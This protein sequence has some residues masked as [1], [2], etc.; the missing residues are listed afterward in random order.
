MSRATLGGLVGRSTEWVKAVES[1]RLLAPRLPMLIQLA[2]VLGV[3]DLAELTGDPTLPVSVYTRSAHESLSTIA[4]VLTTYTIG[5]DVGGREPSVV[6]LAGSVRQAWELWHG[7]RRHRTAVATVL[8]GLLDQARRCARHLEGVERRRAQALLA[9]VNHLAQLYL[10][11]QPR[12]ELVYLAGDR[13]MIA[14]QDADDPL[15]LAAA[16]WYLNHVFRDAGEAHEARVDLA[17]QVGRLLRPES[18]AEDLARSGVL[19]LAMALS[20]A[21]VGQDGDAWRH[22]DT[23]DRAA[24]ALGDGY[25]HP[26]LMFGRGMVDAYAVTLHTDLMRPGEAVRA[27]DRLDFDSMP[28]V[29]RRSFHLIET[30][31]AYHQRREP[32]AT[33]HL[34]RRA[35][36]TSPDTARFNL[37]AQRAAADLAVSGGSTVRAD[38]ADL[39][40]KLGLPA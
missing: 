9:Q 36:D 29:T 24:V 27:A 17:E 10:S 35:W 14:A 2:Q 25:T 12:Q 40:D 21:K 15:A 32:V 11:F 7:A 31:R 37:F 38:A 6:E 30:A 13:A 22:W 19:E 3:R 34:L 28:S 23:A 4:D 5:D 16:A 33:V 20:Y 26:W 1:G 8:P 39:A 18:G